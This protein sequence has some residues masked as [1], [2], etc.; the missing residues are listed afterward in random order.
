[1]KDVNPNVKSIA[2]L[3]KKNLPDTF[4]S[5]G[6][7][8]ETQGVYDTSELIKAA[9]AY[10]DT[11]YYELHRPLVSNRKFIGKVVVFFKKVVRRILHPWLT[12]PL[13]EDQI[14][15]NSSVTWALNEIKENLE[16]INRDM[17]E[18][19]QEKDFSK[20]LTNEMT[21]NINKF[22]VEMN[23]KLEKTLN[24]IKPITEQVRD[25]NELQ[26]F[27]Y[28]L[29]ENR[30]RGERSDIKKRQ[31]IYLKYFSNQENV[32]DIGCGRGEFIELLNEHKISAQ[33]IDVNEDM[34]ALCQ[35]LNLPVTKAEAL[36]YLEEL[37]GNSLGGIFLG[38]VVEHLKPR[39][40]IEIVKLAYQKLR[41]GACLIAETPNPLTL[42]IFSSFFYQDIT[43]YQPVH[44]E[45]LKFIFETSGFKPLDVIFLSPFPEESKLEL[46]LDNENLLETEKLNKNIEKLNSLI[47]DSQDYAVVGWKQD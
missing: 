17:I 33:G 31:T 2:N 47:F 26:D 22:K 23:N 34:V 5:N 24:C 10:N 25:V 16:S 38:Q 27:D 30:F 42:G 9:K 29:F 45:T 36:N 11:W 32:L 15:F 12:K 6:S 46:L 21:T 19:K 40:L 43:H 4:N 37:P 44:P 18:I 39:D 14:R 20:N 3:I 8:A 35:S 28:L 13:F 7:S 1:M 41:P